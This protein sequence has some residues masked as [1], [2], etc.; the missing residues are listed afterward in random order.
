MRLEPGNEVTFIG[1]VNSRR[2]IRPR[3]GGQPFVK[4]TVKVD[5]GSVVP[6]VWWDAGRAPRTGARV[7]VRGRV[8]EYDGAPEVHALESVVERT[9]SPS[10][11]T[12][13]VIAFYM[14]CVEA[15]A[16]GS[17]RVRPGGTGHLELTVGTSPVCFDY[18]LP[19]DA[20]VDR[21]CRQREM[22]LGEAIIAG[23][24][25]VIGPDG[26][27]GTTALVASPLLTTDVRLSKSGDKW[28]IGLDGGAVDLNPYALELLGISRDE[29][30][31]LIKLVDETPSVEEAR[32]PTERAVAIL[33]ALAEG[34]VD[35]LESLGSLDPMDLRPHD[36]S[37]GVHNCGMII[38][39]TGSTQITRMLL[40]DLDELLNSPELLSTGPAAVM[41]GQQPA[42]VSALP[43][44]HP[45]VVPSTLAQ[46][47]AITSAMNNV[48]TVVT[49]PPGTGKSQV[50]VNVV[51]AAVARGET[52]LF[53]SNNNQAVDVVFDRL[54]LTS[55]DA[56]IVR[57]GASSRRSE[58]AASITRM[59]AT[60]QRPVEP[61]VAR[62]MW[63]HIERQVRDVHDV[64]HQRARLEGEIDDLQQRLGEELEALPPQVKLDVDESQLGDALEQ[65]RRALSAFAK[66]LGLFRRWKKHQQRLDDGRR[67]LRTL[68]E[69]LGIDTT[70]VDAPLQTVAD[71]P[72]RSLT[73]LQDLGPIEHVVSGITSVNQTR[74]L[75]GRKEAELGALPEKH[76]LDDRLHSISEDRSNAGRSLLDVKWEESRR[77]DPV[78]RKAAGELAELL[79]N[80]ARTGSGARRARGL[81]SA[82]LGCI[83]VW[84]VTNLSARTNLPLTNGLFDLVVIDEAS[85][86]DVASALPLLARAR[87]GMIIGDRRQLVHIASLSRARERVI[88]GR[89]GLS[90][91][92]ADEFSYRNRS[93]FGLASSRVDESP[94]FLDLHFRSHPAIIGFSNEHFYDGRL[95]LCS[96]SRPPTEMNAIEWKRVDGDS[97]TGSHGRSR[98]NPD[99]AAEIASMLAADFSELRGLGMTV[100]VVT[101][102]RAQAELIR[103]RLRRALGDEV[104]RDVTVATAHRFQGD[105]RDV[106]YFSPVVGPSMTERQVAFAAD[107]NL[108]NVALTRAR[109]RLVVVGNIE[110]CLEHRNV[111]AALAR[112]VI[113]LEA[114]S[115]DSPLEQTLHEALLDRGIAAETGVVV[116][117]HRLDLAISQGPNRLDIECD[118]AAF[119][120]D[121]AADSVRDRDIEA[122]GW[123]VLRF[124]GRRLSRDLTGCVDNVL[125]TLAEP[126]G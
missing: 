91:D 115:F 110:A 118:G 39:S 61:V 24:P 81:V 18:E 111:L 76:E 12:A 97:R 90:D 37:E 13:Q 71:K 117:G 19:A 89:A 64:L 77:H 41:L 53:A 63:A 106:I 116:A 92:R 126:G 2:V 82:A 51:A 44:P 40:E 22:A 114:G 75:I 20:G 46:D 11:P 113:R 99:E 29:R 98:V 34:G 47:Q 87:R 102:Y 112:Y 109:R 56:C 68:G 17:T 72:R 31:A 120:I 78:A 95:E 32:L 15:E 50:L 55:P 35:G 42:P 79:E 54:A 8:R 5:G 3:S 121:R 73:P 52:V 125:E 85:Q 6:V 69:L 4:A 80:A 45:S 100:G 9:G 27:G 122:A 33:S 58:V 123:R 60:P 49:G 103:D 28:T 14:G 119:H 65:A 38:L 57:A 83:P 101:P 70:I 62:Q 26:D 93:C 10:D 48:L 105:E 23:W 124:S 94:I 25:M 1:V 96:E 66:R 16:A 59:L 88:A 7:Q 86:C 74:S 43:E 107:P 30:D 21:W 84:G 104:G 67:A 36:G 108:V